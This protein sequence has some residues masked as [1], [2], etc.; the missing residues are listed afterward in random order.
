[1]TE[2][3]LDAKGN[4]TG[5]VDVWLVNEKGEIRDDGNGIFIKDFYINPERRDKSNIAYFAQKVIDKFPQA[6]YGYF[7]KK[8][9]GKLVRYEKAKWLKIINKFMK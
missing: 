1:M 9:S 8:Y 2:Y 4:L 6:V 5:F 7:E 3:S